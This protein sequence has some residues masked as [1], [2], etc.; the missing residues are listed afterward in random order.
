MEGINLM[1]KTAKQ[2]QP[3]VNAMESKCCKK[4][5]T[6]KVDEGKVRDCSMYHWRRAGRKEKASIYY[7]CHHLQY[8]AGMVFVL[9]TN[10]GQRHR[11]TI[12]LQRR[13]STNKLLKIKFFFQ[14]RGYLQRR[15]ERSAGRPKCNIQVNFKFPKNA[16]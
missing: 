8:I 12:S 6:F 10:M 9:K 1:G 7:R 2:V 4:E 5:S 16:I 13:G 14:R 3:K 11:H 15:S